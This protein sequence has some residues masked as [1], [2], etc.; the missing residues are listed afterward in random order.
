M[1]I[2][3]YIHPTRSFHVSVINSLEA[4]VRLYFEGHTVLP[5]TFLDRLGSYH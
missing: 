4:G 3:L 5:I 2:Y 1:V